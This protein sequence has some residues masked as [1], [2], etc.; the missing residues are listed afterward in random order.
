MVQGE[1]RRRHIGHMV[2][3]V[4]F[5]KTTSNY[6]ETHFLYANIV[7]LPCHIRAVPRCCRRLTVTSHLCIF[8]KA[9]L[10]SA[11]RRPLGVKPCFREDALM[12]P[13]PC[14]L[15]IRVKD[16]IFILCHQESLQIHLIVFMLLA[17]SH[18]IV[19]FSNFNDVLK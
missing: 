4:V 14:R 15:Y 10:F 16:A 11:G 6:C 17:G 13:G 18:R 1:V 12:A 3:C 5:A 8:P 19:R 7:S 2:I 9:R